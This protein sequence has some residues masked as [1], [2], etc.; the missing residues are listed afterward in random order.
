[1][2][3]RLPLVSVGPT[4]PANQAPLRAPKEMVTEIEAIAYTKKCLWFLLERSQKNA[5][6]EHYRKRD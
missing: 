1:M 2:T 6:L 5:V 3:R 4:P